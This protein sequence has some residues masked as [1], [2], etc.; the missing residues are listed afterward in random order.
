MLA[1]IFLLRME[2]ILRAAEQAAQPDKTRF[3]PFRLAAASAL[4]GN[5]EKSR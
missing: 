5:Q 3:V 4:P 2:S 1:E